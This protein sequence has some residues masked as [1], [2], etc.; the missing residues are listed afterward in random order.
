MLIQPPIECVTLFMHNRTLTFFHS[1]SLNFFTIQFEVV[2]VVHSYDEQNYLRTIR[3]CL[4]L[5]Q[6][7]DNC[8]Q[9]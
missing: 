5:V 7:H 4:N 8:G 3:I 1:S 9:T 6:P 2:V